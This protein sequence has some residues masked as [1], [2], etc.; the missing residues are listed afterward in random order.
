MRMVSSGGAYAEAIFVAFTTAAR[1]GPPAPKGPEP[2]TH[3]G[4][5]AGATDME[6]KLNGMEINGGRAHDHNEEIEGHQDKKI[7]TDITMED[8]SASETAVGTATDA[9]M[10]TMVDAPA[11]AE[12]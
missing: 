5:Q 9:S 7:K 8:D 6:A 4:M 12:E 11:D 2:N 3:R 1:M 10:D